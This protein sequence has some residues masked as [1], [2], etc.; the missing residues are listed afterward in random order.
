MLALTLVS[1]PLEGEGYTE[2]LEEAIGHERRAP[3]VGRV[4]EEHRELVP[5]QARDGVRRAQARLEPPRHLREHAVSGSLPE[6]V[7]HGLEVVEVQAEEGQ[8][9]ALAP[10]PGQGMGQPI[11]QKR[12]VG[13]PG[14]GVVE[15]Q[16]ADSILEALALVHVA[17]GHHHPLDARLGQEA[18]GR[19]LDVPP[20]AVRLPHPPVRG[21]GRARQVR[22]L[23]QEVEATI[24]VRGVKEAGQ[25]LALELGAPVTEDA[26]HRRREVAHPVLRIHHH[27]HVGGVLHQGPEPHLALPRRLLALEP[28]VR[29]L[30]HRLPREHHPGEGDGA[31]HQGPD[32]RRPVAR[33][34]QDQHPVAHDRGGVGEEVE[35]TRRALDRHR[36][37][38]L[39]QPAEH[40]SAHP[41]AEP[42]R[43]EERVGHPSGRHHARERVPALDQVSHELD[44]EAGH[45]PQERA[46]SRVLRPGEDGD[47]RGQQQHQVAHREGQV[48]GRS[49]R[50]APAQGGRGPDHEVPHH[51]ASA[52][53]H[54]GRVQPELHP[55]APVLE[56]RRKPQKAE[57]EEGVVGEIEEAR[58][59]GRGRGLEHD[60]VDEP[61]GVAEKVGEGSE[62]QAEPGPPRLGR[63]SEGP[64]RAPGQDRRQQA[65]GQETHVGDE[66]L[67]VSGP[68]P[69]EEDQEPRAVDAERGREQAAVRASCQHLRLQAVPVL[70]PDPRGRARG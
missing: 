15:G 36:P 3:R 47:C 53:Q 33:H 21:A 26:L 38:L 69:R 49:E 10:G 14:Q 16:V 44:Q 41:V 28:Q 34:G 42:M 48:E 32:A 23:G 11:A 13:E 1:P 24:H 57:Q 56:H 54:D 62:G 40:V 35:G 4:L 2:R 37:A 19:D 66:G 59:R 29:A 7:V 64:R 31:S 58:G 61:E 65:G 12:P 63:D 5:G 46:P 30:G 20:G 55:P 68:A 60:L 8:G 45:E 25:G 43:H 51:H 9:P 67:E 70:S 39:S 18:E 22:C 6:A 27:D 50:R 52:E 17:Q